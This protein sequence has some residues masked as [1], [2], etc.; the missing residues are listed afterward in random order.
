MLMTQVEVAFADEVTQKGWGHSRAKGCEDRAVT[1]SAYAT[2]ALPQ[3]T[4]DAVV[5]GGGAAGPNAAL[6]LARSRHSVVVI[7]SA[8]PATRLPKPCTASSCWTASRPPSCSSGADSR[9]ATTAGGASS[10]R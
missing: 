7:D 9:C 3:G 6:M 10:A 4:V 1:A 8:T 5:I 2:D